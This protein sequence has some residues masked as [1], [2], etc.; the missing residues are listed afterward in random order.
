MTIFRDDCV[1][2]KDKNLLCLVENK[3]CKDKPASQEMSM[4]TVSMLY[5]SELGLFTI[6]L[7]VIGWSLNELKQDRHLIYF[8]L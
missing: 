3:V 5:E 2:E 4:E 7:S 8:S 6:L 1:T